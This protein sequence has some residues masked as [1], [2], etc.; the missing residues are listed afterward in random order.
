LKRGLPADGAPRRQPGDVTEEEAMISEN[1][2][3]QPDTSDPEKYMR[4]SQYA[5]YDEKVRHYV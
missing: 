2:Y 3:Y 4:Q 1:E 5:A